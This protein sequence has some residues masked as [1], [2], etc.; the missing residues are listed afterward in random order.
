M[1]GPLELIDPPHLTRELLFF[2]FLPGLLFEAAYH[3][4]FAEFRR[5]AV[6]IGAL[7]VPGALVAAGLTALVIT[8]LADTLHVASGFG[9][10]EGLV[11]GAVIA[12]PST[13]A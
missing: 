6:S 12:A 8:P 13:P 10:A 5:H 7:A 1:L 3:L 2:V 11:F 9:W 4:E